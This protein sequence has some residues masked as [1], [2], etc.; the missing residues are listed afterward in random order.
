M[1]SNVSVV[2]EQDGPRYFARTIGLIAIG[3]A[4]LLLAMTA[5]F[6]YYR[7]LDHWPRLRTMDVEIIDLKIELA[8]TSPDVD[9]VV[10]GDSAANHG[11]DPGVVLRQTGITVLN[12]ATAGGI[13][14]DVFLNT[15]FAAHRKIPIVVLYQ[16]ARA[17]YLDSLFKGSFENAYLT[18]RYEDLWSAL[19]GFGDLP[20][21]APTMAYEVLADLLWRDVRGNDQPAIAWMKKTGGF[22]PYGV[23]ATSA[24]PLADC[25]LNSTAAGMSVAPLVAIRDHYRAQGVPFYLYVAPMPECD[26]SYSNFQSIYRG[27]ADNALARLPSHDFADYAHPIEGGSTATSLLFGE[28]LSGITKPVP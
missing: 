21:L 12:L 2:V 23:I 16:T 25:S 8:R 19:K 27:T 15:Y 26:V 28:F 11:V 1:T 4:C 20:S 9:V 5:A 13:G 17:P 22:V 7:F 18:A 24:V 14:I 10:V 3:C 6:A